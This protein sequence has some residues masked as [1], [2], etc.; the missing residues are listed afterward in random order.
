MPHAVTDDGVKLYYE[1]AGDGP[2]IIFVHEFADDIVGWEPQ[3]RC[4]SRNYRC[5]AFNAR[6]FPPSD[7][8]EEVSSYSQLRAAEDVRDVLKH[9]KIDKAHIVGISQGGFAVLHFGLN[10]P[11]MALSLMVGGCGYGAGGDRDEWKAQ[12][13][14]IAD[15][16]EAEGMEAVGAFYTLGPT[17]VQ[18]QNKDRRGFD[19]FVARFNQQS[20]LGRANT[21]R[22][23]QRERPSVYD[24]T[25]GMANMKVPTLIMTGDED[26]PCLDPNVM[27]KR[28]MPYAWLAVLPASG[29][30]I[31]L[32]EPDLFNL[33]LQKFFTAVETGGFK[34]RDPRSVSQSMTGLK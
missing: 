27:M 10:F 16:F 8:P 24:L 28:A 6:G 19:E 31:N 3:I 7:V 29:H 13:D 18:F 32:E 14:E 5:I 34:P 2:P 20:T 1:E 33:L 17:R 25:E 12:V 21:M 9:L 15:K 26:E 11:E 4:F 23:V 30:A 22:G